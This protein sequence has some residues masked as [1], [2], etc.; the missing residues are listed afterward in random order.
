MPDI[1]LIISAKKA[2]KVSFANAQNSRK[3]NDITILRHYIDR[4]YSAK[5]DN[6]P[7]FQ[8]MI[9][10]GNKKLFDLVIVWKLDRFARNRYDSARYKAALK[11][12]G[13]KVVSATKVISNGAEG[14]ILESVL[15]GYAEYY[16]ADLSEKV[17]RGMTENTL[18]G[19]HN[20]GTTT[21]GYIVN[22]KQQLEID[23]VTAPFV[24]EAFR[25][26][27]EGCTMKDLMDW[28]NTSGFTNTR[29]GPVSYNTIQHMLKNRR[30]I[31]EYRFRDIVLAEVIPPIVPVELFN[32]VQE[33]MVQNKRAP[34]RHKAIDDY[35]LTTKL[36]LVIAD[37][38]SLE[39]VGQADRKLSTIIINAQPSRDGQEIAKRSLF[40]KNFWKIWSS[41]Q[42]WSLS[43]AM[44]QSKSWSH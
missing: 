16:S 21:I 9:K 1:L 39:N 12:N 42:Q 14:I 5:T 41:R 22:K 24:L 23:P 19:K 17:I 20:G 36:F 43:V 27:D 11:K 6:R 7:E 44:Q 4:A 8:N 35:L 33:R 38:F 30:Y 18:K 37:P 29:G 26:Y 15:E 32:R 10:D 13:I 34:A 25:R 40:G 3:K 2:L 31:G 28:L